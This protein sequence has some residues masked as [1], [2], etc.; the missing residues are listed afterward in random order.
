MGPPI[1]PLSPVHADA[2]ESGKNQ[3]RTEW[4]KHNCNLLTPRGIGRSYFRRAAE[5]AY[6]DGGRRINASFLREPG[7][8]KTTVQS[9]LHRETQSQNKT[10][11]IP[12]LFYVN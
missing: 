7:Q 10:G 2:S 6:G 8:H 3:V 4:T 5:H 1:L 11:P 12:T 9:R